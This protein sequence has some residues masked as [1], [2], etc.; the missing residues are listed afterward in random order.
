MVITIVENQYYTIEFLKEK[1]GYSYKEI[2]NLCEKKRIII[3]DSTYQSL[4]FLDLYHSI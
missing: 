4:S 3:W 1:L 2:L